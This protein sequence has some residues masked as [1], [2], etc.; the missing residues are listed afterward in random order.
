MSLVQM[1]NR[2]IKKKLFVK[3]KN[4]YCSELYK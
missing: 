2:T 4:V 3:M 1:F